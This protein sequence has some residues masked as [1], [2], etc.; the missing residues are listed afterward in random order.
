MEI[1]QIER[2]KP[3]S[4]VYLGKRYWISTRNGIKT[5]KMET[6][7]ETLIPLSLPT[8]TKNGKPNSMLTPYMDDLADKYD[9]YGRK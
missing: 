4:N 2:P 3:V 9:E 7:G 1:N 8:H 5:V 6:F